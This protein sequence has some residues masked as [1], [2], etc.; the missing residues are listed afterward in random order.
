MLILIR[1]CAL[2]VLRK[3]LQLVYL[4]AIKTASNCWQCMHTYT[5]VKRLKDKYEISSKRTVIKND[6]LYP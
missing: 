6:A 5:K 3:F 4:T 1:I 2:Q